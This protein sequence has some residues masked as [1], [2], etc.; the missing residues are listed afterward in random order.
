M[1]MKTKRPRSNLDV[2]ETRQNPAHFGF[3]V[4]VINPRNGWAELLP[5]ELDIV[6]ALR[7]IDT[8]SAEGAK[9]YSRPVVLSSK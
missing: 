5:E 3:C 4:E 6:S 7:V 1:A 2:K 8:L 9:L